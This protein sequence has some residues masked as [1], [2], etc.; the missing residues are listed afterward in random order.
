MTIIRN[1]SVSDVPLSDLGGITVEASSDFDLNE[2]SHNDIANSQDL[3]AAIA[4]GDVVFLD[5]AGNQLTQQESLDTQN[6][7]S[8]TQPAI[9]VQEN[10]TNIS[11]TPHNVLNFTGSGVSVVDAG[12]GVAN[13]DA[14][15]GLAFTTIG[16]EQILTLVD[17]SRSNKILSVEKMNYLMVEN[18]VSNG[19]YLDVSYLTN[20]NSGYIMPLDG[21]IV[22]IALHKISGSSSTTMRYDLYVDGSLHTQNLITSNGSSE[23]K[24][25]DNTLNIDLNANEKFI[26]RATRTAGSSTQTDVNIVLYIR[27]RG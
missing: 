15:Q 14:F 18:S 26:I 16:G 5:N 27:W 3:N 13:I 1:L 7:I 24:K 17:A 11:G 22:G 12:N 4:A 9:T 2:E 6:N 20:T 23:Q 25:Q 10:G 19:T 21:T 8:S